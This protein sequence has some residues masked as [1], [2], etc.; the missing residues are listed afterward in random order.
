MKTRLAQHAL[1]ALQVL[2]ASIVLSSAPPAR[3]QGNVAAADPVA[4]SEL[5]RNAQLW[6]RLGRADNLRLVLNKILAVDGGQ[7]RA[8]LLLGEL[9]LRE[10]RSAEAQRLLARLQRG[11]DAAASAELQDLVRVYTR[12]LPRLQQLRLLRRGGNEARAT[13]LARELFPTGNAPGALAEEFAGLLRGG[14]RAAAGPSLPGRTATAAPARA[15]V[16]NPPAAAAAAPAAEDRYWPLL[17]EARALS[18]AGALGDARARV[19]SAMALQPD[20]P[21][22]RLLRADLDARE[23]RRDAAEAGYRAL[24]DDPAAAGVHV[25][26]AARLVVLLQNSGRHEDALADAARSGAANAL[27]SGA[28]RRA[29]EAEQ[30]QGRSGAGL[31]LLEAALAALPRDP[32]LRHD[33]ARLYGHLGQIETARDLL[34]EGRAAAPEDAE[35]AYAAALACAALDR[36]AEALATLDAVPEG[37]RSEGQRALAQRLRDARA[38]AEAR[39]SAEPVAAAAAIVR[40]IAERNA[41]RQPTDEVALFPYARRA[42]D[43]RSSLRGLEMPIVVTRPEGVPDDGTDG[44]ALAHGHRWLHVDPVRIDAGALPAS[45][46]EASEFG[47]VRVGGQPLPAPL[48]QRARGLNLGLGWTGDERRWDL[49]IVGAGFEVPNLVGGWRQA[50]SLRGQDA[51][52]ELSRRVLTGGLLPYAG[53]RDPLSGRR[54]GGVTMS[55]AT[56][57]VAGDISGWSSSASLRAGLLEGRNVAG[58]DTVQLR[59]AS[60]RDWLDGVALRLSAGATLSLWHYRRNLSFHTFGHGGYYSPQRY[61]SLALP[62][63]AQGRQGAWSYRARA[64]VGRSW[65]YEANAPYHPTDPALQAATGHAV[66]AGGRGGGTSTSLRAEIE[67]RLSPH[68]SAGASVFADRSAYYSPTQW[69]FYLRRNLSPQTGEMSSPRPVQPY[70]QF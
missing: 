42:A 1:L 3:A 67:R 46:G 17:R 4:I 63:D 69:M 57:R 27:D 47:T 26:A 2:A 25:R 66:H 19:A 58:N 52:I 28:L 65:T 70:S 10:G 8:L 6:L 39:R 22:G 38:Q 53:T 14:G 62:V 56:L 16:P 68:W 33:L 41:W 40:R 5:L 30:A 18:D 36:D 7:A 15:P 13:G 50:F 31:R 48:P 11:G 9:E 45:F 60:D 37:A 61:A 32:W 24:L 51:S 23:D 43:G 44:R 20:E 35:Q 64:S 49:G 34:A 29:A 21:E 55:T 12:D 59:L 54:W